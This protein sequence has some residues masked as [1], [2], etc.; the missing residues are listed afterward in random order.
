MEMWD[1]EEILWSCSN[2]AV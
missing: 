2:S 1:W